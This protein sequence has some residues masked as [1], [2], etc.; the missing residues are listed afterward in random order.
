MEEEHISVTLHQ[1]DV[2]TLLAQRNRVSIGELASLL[3]VSYVAV[4][5]VVNRLEQKQ[6][7]ERVVD[8]WDRRRVF[9]SLTPAGW[10]I[11]NERF[12]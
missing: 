2:L 7:V 1:R 12:E 8:E 5:K 11:L 6:L 9:V 10:R 3:D 4:I